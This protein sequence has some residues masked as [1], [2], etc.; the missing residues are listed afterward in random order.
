MQTNPLLPMQNI[1]ELSDLDM[2]YVYEITKFVVDASP[3]KLSNGEVSDSEVRELLLQWVTKNQKKLD[4]YVAKA[5]STTTMEFIFNL[6][7]TLSKNHLND[8]SLFN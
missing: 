6:G 7:M 3:K 2:K 5:K 8:K 4:A 1:L